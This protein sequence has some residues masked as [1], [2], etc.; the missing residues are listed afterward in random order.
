MFIYPLLE[1]KTT[2]TTTP[3]ITSELRDGQNNL[4]VIYS[5]IFNSTWD[6]DHLAFGK[7]RKIHSRNSWEMLG[8]WRTL[9]TKKP[10]FCID[11]II[12]LLTQFLTLD[13]TS[14]WHQLS[15]Y[16]NCC[17]HFSSGLHHGTSPF[18]DKEYWSNNKVEAESKNLNKTTQANKHG[19]SAY[20]SLVGILTL[21][22]MNLRSP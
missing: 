8:I 14:N 17:S 22:Y 6:T 13:P 18:I 7:R 4:S 19:C 20:P 12:S 21:I 3:G 1:G 16:Q 5:I 11:E 9:Q 15:Y 2:T 10:V